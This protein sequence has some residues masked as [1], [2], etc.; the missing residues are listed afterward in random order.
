MIYLSAGHATNDPGAVSN[1]TTEFTVT[2]TIAET[3]WSRNKTMIKLV[4]VGI[5]L[6]QRIGWL[7]THSTSN[8]F[9]IEL[10]MNSGNEVAHGAEMYFRA[11]SESDRQ[12]AQKYIDSYCDSS[13]IWNRGVH[14]DTSTRHKRLGILRDVKPRGLLLEM[15]F[16]TNLEDLELVLKNAVNGLEA[17]LQL[18]HEPMNDRPLAEWELTAMKFAV[19]TK[20]MK[21]ERPLEN[22]TRV[23]VAEIFRKF[24]LFWI[25][26]S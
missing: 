11:N 2:K 17:M 5:T 23:E 12:L 8:D 15:G 7:N 3:L 4:P 25:N 16:I 1:N 21:D 18:N 24:Y 13:K 10:H 19:D 26:K 9:L 14:A 20:I 22:I 6:K